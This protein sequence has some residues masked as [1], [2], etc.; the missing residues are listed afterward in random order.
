MII[1]YEK[2]TGVYKKLVKENC[3]HLGEGAI[4]DCNSN[5]LHRFKE[6]S[7]I[8]RWFISESKGE[9]VIIYPCNLR[10]NCRTLDVCVESYIVRKNNCDMIY[11]NILNNDYSRRN[12]GTYKEINLKESNLY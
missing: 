5:I 4:L 2:L 1:A 12:I 10:D 3:I 6:V 7:E 8:K 11:E 9:I